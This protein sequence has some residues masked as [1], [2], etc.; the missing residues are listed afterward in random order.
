MHAHIKYLCAGNLLTVVIF[1]NREYTCSDFM[2]DYIKQTKSCIIY[3]FHRNTAPSVRQKTFH[4][5][6]CFNTILTTN[7]ALLVMQ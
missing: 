7:I 3:K 1:P 5:K 2:P 4:L 6:S